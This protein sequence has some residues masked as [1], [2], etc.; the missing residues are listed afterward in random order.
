LLALLLLEVFQDVVNFWQCRV[1]GF[2]MQKVK[3]LFC[4]YALEEEIVYAFSKGGIC[5]HKKEFVIE[6]ENGGHFQLF[7]RNHWLDEYDCSYNFISYN[8]MQQSIA[9]ENAK[10]LLGLHPDRV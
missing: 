2:L 9:H 3:L 10:D 5:K 1:K 8:L 4:G 7:Y 6:S